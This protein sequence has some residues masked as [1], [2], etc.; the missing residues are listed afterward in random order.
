VR[1]TF[2]WKI[3]IVIAFSTILKRVLLSLEPFIRVSHAN[4]LRLAELKRMQ[5]AESMDKVIDLLLDPRFEAMARERMLDD[6]KSPKVHEKFV[7]RSTKVP[8]SRK[9]KRKA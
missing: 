3:Y 1:L 8:A 7:V 4:Y 6:L 5:G 9:A 2:S